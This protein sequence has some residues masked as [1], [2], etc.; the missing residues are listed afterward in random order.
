MQ[1]SVQAC[2]FFALA[3]GS[4]VSDLLDQ[5]DSEYD[6]RLDGLLQTE[7]S[8]I[9]ARQSL[10]ILSDY[11]IE[12]SQQS[13]PITRFYSISFPGHQHPAQIGLIGS[14]SETMLPTTLENLAFWGLIDSGLPWHSSL[15]ATGAALVP[16]RQTMAG[17]AI[18]ACPRTVAHHAQLR[19]VL[20][21]LFSLTHPDLPK[22]RING[23]VVSVVTDLSANIE[24]SLSITKVRLLSDAM[25]EVNPKWRFL[26]FYRIVEH[27]YLS[28]IKQILV[29][30]FERDAK[31]AVKRAGDSLSSEP[32][33]LVTLTESI[34]LREEF[35][36][37]SSEVDNLLM[38]GNQFMKQVDAGAKG[39][40]LYGA[41]DLYKKGIIRLYKLRC[42]IAHGGTSSVIFEEFTDAND[43]VIHLMKKVEIIAL[44]SMNIRLL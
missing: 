16:W 18:V 6:G 30:E 15:L 40:S 5:L 17:A 4:S 14:E 41:L 44:K 13:V 1:L 19:R 39:E 21:A 27:A 25:A 33:Q 26:S 37:F 43:A 11:A 20:A 10:L 7:E 34:N 28:N 32:N 8:R 23:S 9:A 3:Q 29:S 22:S 31:A 36:S 35:T 2:N 24:D 12:I 38:S 42:S